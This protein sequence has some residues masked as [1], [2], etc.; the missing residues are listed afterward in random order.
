MIQMMISN[1]CAC[2]CVCMHVCVH[3]Y[4]RP[5][6]RIH[7]IRYDFVIMIILVLSTIS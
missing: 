4:V 1:T 3:A 7:I 5:C 6:N 2:V